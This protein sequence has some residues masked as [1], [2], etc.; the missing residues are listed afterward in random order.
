MSVIGGRGCEKASV[1][2]LEVRGRN[3]VSGT[4]TATP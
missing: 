4:Y 2:A 1:W 3:I